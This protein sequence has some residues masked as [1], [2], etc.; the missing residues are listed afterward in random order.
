MKTLTAL[1]SLLLFTM[2]GFAQQPKLSSHPSARATIFLDF[3]GHYVEGT[4]WNSGNPFYCESPNLT[5]EQIT[6]IFHRVSED[7]RPF[8]VNVTTDSTVFLAAP[9]TQ[10]IRVVITPSPSWAPRAGGVSFTGS[11]TW[12]DETPLFVFPDMLSW[13]TKSIAECCSHEAGHTLGLSHQAKYD[14]NCK[15][16]NVYN[17][18]KGAGETSWAP[19]MGNSYGRNFSSWNNGP[20]PTGC[21][22]EQDNLSII[23]SGN[24][25]SY[26]ED[27]H[28][29]NPTKATKLELTSNSFSGDGIVTTNEDIDFFEVFF[30]SVGRLIL[31]A[32]PFSVGPNNAG[33]NLDI[34]LKIFTEYGDLVGTYNPETLL[35]ATADVVLEPGKYFI[36]V[37][38]AGNQYTSNYGSLG[39]YSFT[40]AF[41]PF[42]TN[43]VSSI[44]LTGKQDRNGHLL[45]WNIVCDEAL[46][47]QEIQVSY[48]GINF[49]KVAE[50]N[51][52]ARAFR[53]DPE[54]AG[55]IF[56]RLK[57]VTK[58][59]LTSYSNGI[60]ILKK[61]NAGF[62]IRATVVTNQVEVSADEN[63]RYIVSDMNG[64]I[65]QKGNGTSGN[66]VINIAN[67]PKGIYII[68]IAG[69]SQRITERIVRM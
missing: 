21:M 68:Q 2:T 23:T 56:Y 41:S 54:K 51:G 31:D 26:R 6:E 50:L 60:S 37:R 3:D 10:R 11:F 8:D 42:S 36:S 25:F 13:K 18:G 22:S 61:G 34:E 16:V 69:N 43:P 4:L 35:N 1:C 14:D 58:S 44:E 48:D 30:P 12:G 39:S 9:L 32:K 62:S 45:T 47:L 64:K 46:I 49:K 67:T 7:F 40:G 38:G 55:N 53:Y 33:A 29:D 17:D 19:V 52:E 57:V 59:N 28:G 15:L 63:F 5:N 27:D 65:L 24:G 20:T 66:N